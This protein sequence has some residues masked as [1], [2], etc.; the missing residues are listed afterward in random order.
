MRRLSLRFL[1]TALAL[2]AVGAVAHADLAPVVTVKENW[3]PNISKV[4]ANGADPS[5][6]PNDHY[7]SF[8]NEPDHFID[9][10]TQ[11]AP[12]GLGP[13]QVL[14]TNLNAAT[15]AT[16]ANPDKVSTSYTLSL[17]LTGDGGPGDTAAL[18]FTGKLDATFYNFVGSD[19]KRHTFFNAQNQY[20]SPITQQTTLDGNTIT[21]TLDPFAHPTTGSTNNGSIGAEIT[22]Q[23]PPGGGD[24]N[25]GGN[26]DNGGPG[27]SRSPEPSTLLLAGLGLSAL[28]GRLWWKRR[29]GCGA[30]PA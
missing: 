13:N 27:P 24:N 28:G 14:V 29:R 4:Y 5:A 23:I 2:L 21:V 15:S 1:G 20:T 30:H 19:G 16:S 10:P 22:A 9:I 3:F 11:N 25:G 26:K 12:P 18:N 17:V 8:S 7:I 6:T